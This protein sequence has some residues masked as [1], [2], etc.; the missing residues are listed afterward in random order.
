MIVAS[1]CT[2]PE[3][4]EDFKQ[5][6]AQILFGQTLPI[7][8][9]HIW[10][11]GYQQIDGDLPQ[12]SRLIYHL[13]PSNPGPWIRYCA[14]DKETDFRVL[15][16]LDDDILYPDDYVAKGCTYLERHGA[17]ECISFGGILWDYS[18]PTRQ[19]SY[20]EGRRFYGLMDAVFSE[21][22][23]AIPL[24]ALS[25]YRS[26]QVHHIVELPFKEFRTN[27]D[28]MIGW[29]LQRRNVS[30]ICCPAAAKWVRLFDSAQK[31]HAL[32]I[33]DVS[34]R[35]RA[36]RKMINNLGF[37]PTAENL[38][39]VMKKAQRILVLSDNCPPLPGSKSLDLLLQE[40][41]SN[42]A[43]VHLLAFVP[44]SQV[45]IVQ[46]YVNI[47]YEIHAINVPE[48]GGRFEQVA[49]IRVW[50]N[51]RVQRSRQTRW[52]RRLAL[53]YE[54]LKPTQVYRF[55]DDQLIPLKAAYEP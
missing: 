47:L 22:R 33:R 1:M 11:N 19:L 49:P 39:M 54:R 3:R 32:A 28:M 6:C 35:Y 17:N 41:C 9:L 15:L 50:R 45:P 26:S 5:T 48:P 29:Q 10:L 31:D 46:H 27:D 55:Q 21:R 52:A 44:S 38:S 18:V 37:D 34:N 53:A 43:S 14:A 40:R 51:W 8:R 16:T 42:D 2:I 24:G 13:E 23:V 25:F 20:S 30:I 4:K 7:E 36:F 12:D